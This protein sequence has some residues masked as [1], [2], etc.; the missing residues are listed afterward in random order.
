MIWDQRS[1]AILI[2]IILVAG[3]GG[4]YG[5]FAFDS[6][7]VELTD[8]AKTV[9]TQAKGDSFKAKASE[10]AASE[11]KSDSKSASNSNTT[12]NTSGKATTKGGMVDVYVTGAVR[13]V[14]VVKVPADAKVIDAV[15]KAGGLLPTAEPASV[16]MAAPVADGMHVHVLYQGEK[17]ENA[18]GSGDLININTADKTEL[19]KIK[20]VGNTTADRIIEYRKLHGNFQKL[21]DLKKV[22]GIGD[23][24]FD[25][26]KDQ[27]TI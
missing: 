20:G 21:E 1:L 17:Q 12:S 6:D 9:E 24:T 26:L 8:H 10:G 25:K 19:T 5:A 4:L 3:L 23:K 7:S 2:I 27:I 16:N 14:A 22:K 15:E 11:E 18:T 13:E